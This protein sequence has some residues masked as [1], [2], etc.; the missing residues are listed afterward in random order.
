MR[1][2]ESDALI[3]QVVDDKTFDESVAIVSHLEAKNEL[4]I[5]GQCGV[6]NTLALR[7]SL[8]HDKVRYPRNYVL[9]KMD[10]CI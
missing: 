3:Q 7:K 8:V 1:K 6:Q 5:A 4:G 9:E 10:L 2:T